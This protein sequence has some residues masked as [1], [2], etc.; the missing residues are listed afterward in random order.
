MLG[1][2][3]RMLIVAPGLIFRGFNPGKMRK[4]RTFWEIS[5]ISDFGNQLWSKDFA[6]TVH[7]N[8]RF[9]LWQFGRKLFHLGFENRNCF[10][11]LVE[12]RDRA[13]NKCFGK[14][15]FL[16]C[17]EMSCGSS[18][19]I[20]GFLSGKVITFFAAPL[21]ILLSKSF[22]KNQYN[23]LTMSKISNKINTFFVTVR[24][25]CRA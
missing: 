7:S 25:P 10:T 12:L 5:N 2:A 17:A 6:N 14:I 21:L 13:G 23:A 1:N 4:Q 11:K 16:Q 3:P 24:L 20:F 18:V 19:N 22:L 9:I 8:N 15:I